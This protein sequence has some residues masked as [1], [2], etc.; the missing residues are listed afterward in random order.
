LNPQTTPQILRCLT[1]GGYTARVQGDGLRIRGPRP[2]AG[3]LP[4]S[5]AERR[6]ELV[7]FLNEWCDGAWPPAPGSGLRE[8][9]RVLGCGLAG[10]LDAVEAEAEGAA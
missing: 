7:G 2:L 4:A 8:V 10:T 6:G 3:P 1:L 5:I 9:E